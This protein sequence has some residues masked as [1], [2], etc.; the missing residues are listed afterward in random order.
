MLRKFRTFLKSA[1]RR[2][3]RPREIMLHIGTHR[4]GSTSIQAF[5]AKNRRAL[6]RQGLRVYRGSIEPNNH[7]ELYLAAMR[8][9]RDSL[10]KMKMKRPF[11]SS[12]VE[13]ARSRIHRF[14]DSA[15]AE[16]V[17]FTTEGLSLL[18]F[19]DEL[20]RLLEL[21]RAEEHHVSVILYL[22]NRD[23]FLSSYR[24]QLAKQPG[25]EPSSNRDSV[26]YVEPDSWLADYDHLLEV[27]RAAFGTDAIHVINYDAELDR[28]GSV[29][30][31]FVAKLGVDPSALDV[32][33]PWLNA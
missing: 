16:K 26:L 20:E 2:G 4:T 25:R 11:D 12:A 9:E 19:P 6:G 14:L 18:R 22:R 24:R 23:D 33:D 29:I 8:P 1:R 7:T 27:W 3:R 28:A 30:P 15:D 13:R 32:R 21:I 17:L 10:A 31:S 5:L